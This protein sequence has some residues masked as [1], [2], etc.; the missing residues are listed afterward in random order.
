[1]TIMHLNWASLCARPCLPPSGVTSDALAPW[2]LWNLWK[3]RNKF[4]F[5]GLSVP[6]EDISLAKERCSNQKNEPSASSNLLR[7]PPQET[8]PVALMAERL[9][10]LEAVRTGVKEERRMVCFES[11][12]ALVIKAV[13]SGTCIPE[14]YGGV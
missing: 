7:R 4:V 12:Y 10:L 1:M 9:V 8:L 13:S 3:A 5:E 6:P 2:I 11:D 14:L